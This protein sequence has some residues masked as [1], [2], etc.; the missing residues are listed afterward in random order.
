MKHLTD[1]KFTMIAKLANLSHDQ[2]SRLNPGYLN[3]AL[4]T[5]GTYTFLLPLANAEQ[6]HRLL[7]SISEFMAEPVSLT[8]NNKNTQINDFPYVWDLTPNA[9]SNKQM[10]SPLLSKEI[11]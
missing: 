4:L 8:M 7:T 3:P 11:Y 10:G 5:E 6:L 2:F 1:N 9:S